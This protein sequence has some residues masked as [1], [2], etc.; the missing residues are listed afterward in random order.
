MPRRPTVR[1]FAAQLAAT[2]IAA[3]CASAG[4]SSV[5]PP[6]APTSVR[7]ATAGGLTTTVSSISGDGSVTGDIPAPLDSAW[8]RLPAVYASL[9]IPLT[10]LNDTSHF[11]G[12]EGLKIRRTLGGQ[13]LMRYLDCGSGSG[14][15]NAETFDVRLAVFT[16]LRAVSRTQSAASTTVQASA[17]NPSFA[18]PEMA[19]RSTGLLEQRINDLLEQVMNQ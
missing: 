7:I 11:L 2:L 19:C 5:E 18:G 17:R 8:R 1:S 6:R 10:M 16:Q 9:R 3:G 12:N 4:G 15:P 13:P 14:G